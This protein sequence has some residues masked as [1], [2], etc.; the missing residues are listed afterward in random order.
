MKQLLNDA[1]NI[2]KKD[3]AAKSIF[4]V[5]ICYPGYHILIFYRF[6]H[7]LYKNKFYVL[8]RLVSNLGRFFTGIDIHPGAAIGK[9]LFIDH[10]MGVVIG[11]T[12][13][14]GDYVTIYHGVTL[15]GT[16]K[17][18]SGRRHPAVEDNA[19]IGAGA[20]VL[21]AITVGMN[22]KVGANAVVLQDV[23]SNSTVVG[24]PARM[25][26]RSLN[27]VINFYNDMVI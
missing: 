13:I 1:R 27:R 14:V 10:G 24:I 20:K 4:E 11:E 6:A 15:G 21:G 16:G 25:V 23:P 18:T 2:M 22:S 5:L 19:I 7:L 12:A 26:K 3:P 17:E 9:G 8:A